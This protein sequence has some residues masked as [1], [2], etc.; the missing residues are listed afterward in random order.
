MIKLTTKQEIEILENLGNFIANGSSRVVYDYNN[1]YV[2][3]VALDEKGQYQNSVEVRNYHDYGDTHLARIQSYGEYTI[4]MEKIDE[5]DCCLVVDI[6]ES[7]D[8]DEFIDKKSHRH[9]NENIDED[10]FYKIQETI[11]ALEEWNGSTEDNYQIGTVGNRIV[12]YDYGFEESNFD[13]CV[14]NLSDQCDSV[15][16]KVGLAVL[17][18]LRGIEQRDEI[19]ENYGLVEDRWFVE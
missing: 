7:E 1:N 12:A 10:L 17:D 11:G 4:V 5:L 13:K 6:W 16:K 2:V 15:L 14:S 9:K 3:K 18:I 8:Y 19:L